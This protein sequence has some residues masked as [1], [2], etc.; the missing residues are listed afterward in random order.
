MTLFYLMDEFYIRLYCSHDIAL[1][2]LYHRALHGIGGG[3]S[4]DVSIHRPNV[5]QATSRSIDANIILRGDLAES[6]ST[7][8]VD[9]VLT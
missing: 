5:T 4:F 8:A 2:P 1:T 6:S 9:V 7:A 3:E